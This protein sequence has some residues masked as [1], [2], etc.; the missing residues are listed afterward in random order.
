MCIY[1]HVYILYLIYILY[2]LY[3]S[4][5]H[6]Y[7]FAVKSMT[8]THGFCIIALFNS[9]QLVCRNS[10]HT[11]L[12][13]MLFFLYTILVSIFL[14]TKTRV[15]TGQFDI[16]KYQVQQNQESIVYWDGFAKAILVNQHMHRKPV[17]KR[18]Y[19][20]HL[21]FNFYDLSNACLFCLL[22]KLEII[23]NDIIRF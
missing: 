5:Y 9:F 14:I 12:F 7:A 3:K 16:A 23:K 15:S 20:T 1:I 17:P 10:S 6:I 8:L 13:L 21:M 18:W 22:I 11:H 4:V 19:T 2:L